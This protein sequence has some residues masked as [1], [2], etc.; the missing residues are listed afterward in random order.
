M[1]TLNMDGPYDL[2]TAKIGAVVT[3]TGPGN[4]ALGYVNDKDTFIVQ[5]VGRSD[6]DVAARLRQ[7]VGEKYKQ[8]KFSYATSAKAAFEKECINYHDFGGSQK[9]DNAIHPD[10]PAGTGWKCPRCNIFD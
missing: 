10:R 8:F 2:T 4:Y 6:R 1:A 5:Y 9:L 7:H 3:K